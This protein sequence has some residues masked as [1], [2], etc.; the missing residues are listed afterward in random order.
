MATFYVVYIRPEDYQTFR[1][2]LHNNI[3][4]AYDK[5]LYFRDKETA[6]HQGGGHAV[7]AVE[8]RPDEFT[9]YCDRIGAARDIH[10]LRGLASEK[11]RR[12][13]E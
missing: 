3:P 6:E 5:W 9:A 1:R 4:D 2:L 7:K 12:E 13:T 10:T 8:I 11:G